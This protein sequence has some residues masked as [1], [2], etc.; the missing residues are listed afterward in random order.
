[1]GDRYRAKGADGL[2]DWSL[3]SLTC[4]PDGVA[5]FAAQG[6][7]EA[8]GRGV[9]AVGQWTSTN[10]GRCVEL[11]FE[12]A[13]DTTL[14]PPPA[15][16]D[17]VAAGGRFAVR[18]RK[19]CATQVFSTAGTS[20]TSNS[21]EYTSYKLEVV[22]N[23]RRSDSAAASQA[24]PL[25]W[26]VH[27]RFTEFDELRKRLESDY[28]SETELHSLFPAKFSVRSAQELFD[29]EIKAEEKLKRKVK[30]GQWIQKVVQC[31]P[32][33]PGVLAFCR[34]HGATAEMATKGSGIGGLDGVDA[35]SRAELVGTVSHNAGISWGVDDLDRRRYLV[36]EG[37]TVGGKVRACATGRRCRHYS[38]TP[39]RMHLTVVV[40]FLT[41]RMAVA[42]MVAAVPTQEF[43]EGETV[44]L[45][46]E[47]GRVISDKTKSRGS[48]TL[49]HLPPRMIIQ[50]DDD[51]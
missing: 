42:V 41:D 20:D 40:P 32:T 51:V 21:G 5:V 24:A 45:R 11:E 23:Q 37:C 50:W 19:V 31:A 44:P 33:H 6:H 1:M 43:V 15:I 25:R 38:P 29:D 18:L 10:E 30:L 39:P 7:P 36:V 46:V 48:P 12:T 3:Y 34:S 26:V 17:K 14:P 9:Y 16:V 2:P 35:V 27:R 22:G 8:R 4:K 49:Y 28:A 47:H 13:T